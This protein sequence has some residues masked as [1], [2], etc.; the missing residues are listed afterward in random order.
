MLG[1]VFS[2]LIFGHCSD[3]YGRKP[4]LLVAVIIEILSG[5]LSALSPSVNIFIFSRFLLAFGCYGRNLTGFL[6]AI[7]SVGTK[8]RAAMG[9]AVQLGWATGYC[10]LPLMAYLI[11]N[12]RHLLLST[13][14]PEIAWLIWLYWIP[15]SPRWLLTHDRNEEAKAIIIAAVKM[16]GLGVKGDDKDL[17][18]DVE[19]KFFALKENLDREREAVTSNSRNQSFWDLWRSPLLILYSLIFYFTWFTNAF[20]YYGISLNVGDL[21]GDLY[22][23]F[24]WTGLVEFPSYFFCM[25]AFKYVGRRP[26]LAANMFGAGVGCLAIVPFYFSGSTTGSSST[27]IL[28]FALFGKF[29]ITSSFGIIYVYSAEVYPTVLRQIGVGSCSVAGRVGSII[30]PFVK[31][32]SQYTNFGVSMLIF[33]VLSGMTGVACIKLPETKDKD[34]PDTIEDVEK[35]RLKK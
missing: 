34:I 6:L 13:T 25:I 29:C 26:L 11:N 12:F 30:A 15:E 10:L 28:V 23:N 19:E 3:K 31:E 8:Y 32:L 7:E 22:W 18:K 9:I 35:L 17:V 14:I 4:S 16:N 20:V 2:A 27:W 24:F 5:F 21:A 1:I 33:G